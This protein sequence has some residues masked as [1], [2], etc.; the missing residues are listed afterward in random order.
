MKPFVLIDYLMINCKLIMNVNS[1]TRFIFGKTMSIEEI[2]FVLQFNL[3]E[4]FLKFI[5]SKYLLYGNFPTLESIFTSK[6]NWKN[7]VGNKITRKVLGQY[8]EKFS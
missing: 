5:S 6:R 2:V 3:F 8:L 7:F 4:V 1:L